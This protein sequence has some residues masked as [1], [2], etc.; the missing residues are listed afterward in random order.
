MIFESYK[1]IKQKCEKLEFNHRPKSLVIFVVK[2]L[3]KTVNVKNIK[4]CKIS[5]I[6]K[7]L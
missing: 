4:T 7:N 3:L 2:I 5:K 6:I 1:K